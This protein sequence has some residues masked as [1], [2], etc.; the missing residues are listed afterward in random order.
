MC[1]KIK[2]ITAV[3]AIFIV[4]VF[5]HPVNAF[6]DTSVNIP[7]INS[8]QGQ[9]DT[10]TTMSISPDGNIIASGS[11]D[12]SVKLTY[13]N[14]L[15]KTI[16]INAHK[17][18]ISKVAFSP[19]GK[20]LATASTDGTINIWGSDSGEL[21]ESLQPHKAAVNSLVFGIDDSTLYSSSDD[22][23]IRA[24]NIQTGYISRI[25]VLNL[26]VNSLALQRYD[27]LLAA[28]TNDNS[29][30]LID[31]KTGIIKRRINQIEDEKVQ[32]KNIIYNPSYKCLV[33]TGEGLKQP[34]IFNINSDYKKE[35]LGQD[36]FL[37]EDLINWDDCAFTSDGNYI[38]D[39][40][41]VNSRINIFNFYSGKFINKIEMS[42]YCIAVSESNI[43]VANVLD[44]IN[45]YNI[46][47][48][49]KI[50]LQSI[51]AT[52]NN[53]SLVKGKPSFIRV[54]GRFSDGTEK[55]IDSS[56]L[57]FE[58]SGIK[59]YISKGIIVPL[60]TGKA[61]ISVSYC[62]ANCIFVVNS[63]GDSSNPRDIKALAL[64][65][66]G[67]F[68]AIDSDRLLIASNDGTSWLDANMC[69]L[70]KLSY[71]VYGDGIFVAA[72][73]KGT[74]MI[75]NDGF[76]WELVDNFTFE[77]FTNLTYDGNYFTLHGDSAIYESLNGLEWTDRKSVV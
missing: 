41:K 38:I 7:L 25:I 44:N 63:V 66:K 19:S 39:C 62:N 5:I 37:H 67:T 73:D 68:A 59:A 47:A 23:T 13:L 58:V 57:D 20:L 61:S 33:C 27:G 18:P 48:L 75:S 32:L 22:G 30:V 14:N 26:P 54:T 11:K 69:S 72:G 56:E 70:N 43:A 9:S 51:S 17:S 6:A 76:T 45:L 55:I 28:L 8:F 52:I 74:V 50:Q 31:V 49:P 77:D 60:E 29:L 24:Y 16:T 53:N 40:D 1:G 42:P 21:I 46:K 65:G 34:I 35:N 71:M 36:F 10:I 4:M 12:E 2:K 15:G 3:A 64:N